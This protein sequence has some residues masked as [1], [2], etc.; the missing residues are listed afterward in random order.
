M[1]GRLVVDGHPD[2]PM[3]DPNSLNL[4]ATVSVKV[5][6][7]FTVLLFKAK[8][9]PAELQTWMFKK[10]RMNVLTGFV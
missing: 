9:N 4:V 10:N 2:P 1:L 3:A 8:E 5:R 6:V 7:R